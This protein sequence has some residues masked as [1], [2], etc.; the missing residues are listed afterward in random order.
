MA[1]IAVTGHRPNKLGGYSDVTFIRLHALA[2]FM[3]KRL[4]PAA[5]ISGMAQGWDMEV[6][7]AAL[8]MQVPLIAAIPFEDQDK[9]WSMATQ[10]RYAGLIKRAS[11]VELV[12]PGTFTPEKFHRRNRWMVDHCERLVALWDPTERAGGTYET[13]QYARLRKI[14]CDN[15]WSVW[16]ALV[17][18]EPRS[19]LASVSSKS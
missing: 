3:L 8:D 12:S 13:M 10:A 6:A 14:P 11:Q 7:Q 1:V 5:V 4:Q 16:L 15:L 9:L 19:T 18:N 17:Q 2:T